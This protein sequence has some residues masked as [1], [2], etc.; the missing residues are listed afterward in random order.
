MGQITTLSGVVSGVRL[1][2]SVSVDTTVSVT[3]GGE[4]TPATTS[5]SSQTVKSEKMNFRIDNRPVHMPVAI[6][7]ANGDVV[8]AAGIQKGEFEAIAVNNHTT[9]TMYWVPEP[10]RV[11][12]IAHIV[13]GVIWLMFHIT[14]WLVIGGAV[15]FLMNK[16][17][18]IGM[19]RQ[20]RATVE[21]AQAPVVKAA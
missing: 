10:S 11:A 9:R 8:T 15:L 1:D 6:N 18:K 16:N 14:G 3:G 13:T 2:T 17:A 7:I 20:A 5:T 4:Y 19:I 21:K 12:E